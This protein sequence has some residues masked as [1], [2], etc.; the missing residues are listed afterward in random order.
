MTA[1]LDTHILIW[2]LNDSPYM[3]FFILKD[4]LSSLAM[5]STMSL[6]FSQFLL[7]DRGSLGSLGSCS[8]EFQ[9]DTLPILGP[10]ASLYLRTV[11]DSA[12]EKQRGEHMAEQ[13][14]PTIEDLLWP[15]LKALENH[16]G[17]ASIQELSEQVASDLELSDEILDIQHKGRSSIRSQLS[18]CLGANR[19]EACRRDRQ[20]VEG[21][22]D[23]HKSW[24]KNSDG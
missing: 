1:L 18:C 12:I 19:S 10:R 17:S 6:L 8:A 22:L 7:S 16:G 5:T 11:V 2:W 24:A 4:S 15:T 14:F 23:D 21:R 20:Y 3:A 9:T 13:Q